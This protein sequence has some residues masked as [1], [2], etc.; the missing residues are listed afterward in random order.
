[1]ITH[2]KEDFSYYLSNRFIGSSA[3]RRIKAKNFPDD[4]RNAR[5]AQ[6]LLE[7][8]SQIEI[9]DDMWEKIEPFYNE[10]DSH[11]L[12]AVTDT[13]RDIG[14]KKNPRDF[15]AWLENLHSN[16]TRS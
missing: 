6:R 4:P 10:S 5:A 2:S 16:L 1:M 7:L 13:N 3:W 14:F 9:P 11:F 12:G 15:S 8:E